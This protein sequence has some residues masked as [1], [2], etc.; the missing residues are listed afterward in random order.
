MNGSRTLKNQL[1]PSVGLVPLVS[2]RSAMFI[3]ICLTLN[4]LSRLSRLWSPRELLLALSGVVVVELLLLVVILLLVVVEFLRLLL[5]EL[6]AL[7]LLVIGLLSLL[8]TQ[9]LALAL[10]ILLQIEVVLRLNVELALVLLC[11]PLLLLLEPLGRLLSFKG[12]RGYLSQLLLEVCQKSA[13]IL[14]QR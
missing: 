13:D 6:I 4:Q 5:V 2:H 7:L 12:T 14:T 9:H 1:Q 11:Q 3:I 10:S 8:L